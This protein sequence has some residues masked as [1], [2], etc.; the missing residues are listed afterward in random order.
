MKAL[1]LSF[2]LIATL[3][4]V[5]GCAT[6]L[7]IRSTPSEATVEIVRENQTNFVLGKTPLLL[8]NDQ[9]QKIQPSGPYRLRLHKEGFQVRE[10]MVASLVGL[11]L[12]ANFEL[13]PLATSTDTNQLVE[14]LF[15]A[16]ALAQKGQ[17]GLAIEKLEGLK[18][19]YPDVVAIFEMLGSLYLIQ[20]N[21][22]LAMQELN[23]ALALDPANR[24]VKVL[25]ESA[26][27]KGG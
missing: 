25:L 5:A 15:A 21:R 9:V 4:F 16:Q 8:T 18:T 3:L 14:Q 11:N 1:G 7:Q 12:E 10:L 13:T 22:A 17:Y 23:R 27:A 6:Q 26:K 2:H 20:G 19:R 24:E